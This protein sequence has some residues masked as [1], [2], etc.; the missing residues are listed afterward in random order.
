MVRLDAALTLRETAGLAQTILPLLDGLME[1]QSAAEDD[2]GKSLLAD[3][4]RL[5]GLASERAAE[6]M[7]ALE[8]LAQRCEEMANLDFT[9]LFDS[10]RQLFSIGYNVDHH[11]L[12]AGYYDL[13][14]SEARLASFLAIAMGQARKEHWF[15]LGRLL[16]T[17]RGTPALI[18]W[19]GSMFEYLMPLLVMPTYEG[20]LLD[21]TYKAIVQRH[22]E[23]GKQR[24]VPWGISE[25]GYNLTDAQLNYQDPG[26]RRA[27][28]GLETGIGGRSGH[29]ALRLGHGA[30]GG[31]ARCLP[32]HGTPDQRRARGGLWIF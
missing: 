22:I 16:T 5:C 10:S 11:R 13:L 2:A 18:S 23:Y 17:S 28:A 6:R 19:S 15:A 20:T 14:A 30:D 21:T 4:R 12:D 9:F 8:Q 31:S 7:A 27:R 29:C 1:D 3:L 32:Q 26:V 25:S 24:G